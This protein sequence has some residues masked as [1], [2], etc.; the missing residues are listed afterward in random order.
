MFQKTNTEMKVLY[1]RK[2]NYMTQKNGSGDCQKES[3]ESG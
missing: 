1:S 2:Q 3:K